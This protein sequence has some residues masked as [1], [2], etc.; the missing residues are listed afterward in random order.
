[1]PHR[2][3]AL[4]FLAVLAVLVL[5]AAESWRRR[6]EY[7][8]AQALFFL[9]VVVL[10]RV[11][12]RAQVPPIPLTPGRGAVIVSNHR[13]S[14]DPFFLQAVSRHVIHWMV[15]RE[16]CEHWAFGW[17]LRLAEVIPVNRG[18]RDA[19]ATRTAMRLVAEGHWVGMFPEGRINMTEQIL[20]PGRPGAALVALKTGVPVLP[21]YIDGSPYGGTEWSPLL[22]PAKVTVKFGELMD[23][24]ATKSSGRDDRAVGELLL[25]TLRTIARLAGRP[26]FQPTLAGRKWKPT[27]TELERGIA[28]LAERSGG[29][30]AIPEA[31]GGRSGSSGKQ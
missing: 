16:Y 9:V 14:V 27:A 4:T 18:G 5:A 26:D 20:L 13:S 30:K 17:F 10:V 31:N 28:A 19:A 12:W 23:V 7:G 15:A 8:P 24:S 11:L 29:R 22:M 6:T 25:Q 2:E 1:M 21:C 3:F